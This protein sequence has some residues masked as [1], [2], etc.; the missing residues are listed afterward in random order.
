M[1]III[2]PRFIFFNHRRKLLFIG[3]FTM[4]LFIYLGIE[5]EGQWFFALHFMPLI[6]TLG[7]LY[8]GIVAGIVIGLLYTA[9]S[10]LIM[11]TEWIPAFSGGLIVVA[12]GVWFHY[13]LRGVSQHRMA[14]LYVVLV[15]MYLGTFLAASELTG[16]GTASVETAMIC[17]ASLISAVIINYIYFYAK[18]QEHLQQELI[19]SEKYQMIGQLAAS[20]SHE[21]RNP[22]TT[23]RG[24]L[25]LMGKDNVDRETLDRY[26][27]HAFEGID[28]A[29]S[30]ITEYLSFSKPSREE[31]KPL[32]IKLE[33]ESVIE[34]LRPYSLLSNITIHMY[35]L[36]EDPLMIAGE[37]KKLRQCLLN[38]MK[39]AVE[40]MPDGGTLTV[41]TKLVGQT[42]QIIIRDTGEGMSAEQLQRLGKPYFSTK[43]SG[44]GLGLMVV[45]Q[46]I[47]DMDG[48]IMFRSKVNQGTICEMHFE[49]LAV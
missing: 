47:K 7:V 2:T 20:I 41:H 35:H 42:I 10:V 31:M 37:A 44:T 4:L 49:S 33:I 30:I 1:F 36:T 28:Q 16:M 22:L 23:T 25:Q 40:A 6:L 14:I 13:K 43:E 26:R 34:W 3:L 9:G 15:A 19:L 8:E 17:I 39:N 32:D 27:K 18:N 11:G 46:M 12:L 5:R 38:V 29:N 45:M 48:R 24:F 21:I